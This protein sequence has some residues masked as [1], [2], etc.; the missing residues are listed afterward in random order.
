VSAGGRSDGGGGGRAGTGIAEVAVDVCVVGGGPAG[1]VVAR[2][3]ARL[4]HAVAVVERGGHAG[5]ERGETL[6]PGAWDVLAYLG[7]TDAVL[8]A[9]A[10]PVA[11]SLT[12]WQGAAIVERTGPR[13]SLAVVRPRLDAGLLELARA[14]GATV[15]QP[16]RAIGATRGASGWEIVVETAGGAVRRLGARVVIDASGRAAWRRDG[17]D[18]TRTTPPTFAMRGVWGGGPLPDEARI[19]ALD[20][21][22]IWG[23]P[24]DGGRYAVVAIADAEPA[25]G[26]DRYRA[27]IERSELFRALASGAA[28]AAGFEVCDATAHAAAT[29][30]EDYLIRVGDASYSLDPLSSAGLHVALGSALHAVAA[31][32]TLLEHP[33]RAALVARFYDDARRAEIARHTAWTAA[34]YA[35]CHWRARPFWHQRT[36]STASAV[37]AYAPPA[38]DPA[39]THVAL[40]AGVA[41]E[42]VPCLAGDLVE[43]RLG[44]C[45]PPARPFVWTDGVAVAPLLAPLQTAPLTPRGLLATWRDVPPARHRALLGWLLEAGIVVPVLEQR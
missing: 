28:L 36:P 41:L 10:R 38:F 42:E 24:I 31:T 45:H 7:I 39:C 5:A 27:M 43:S 32:H 13:A 3:L 4:G 17:R 18:R 15:L 21:G 16:A 14:A 19:E 40:A 29:G 20:D 11:R 12:R 8:A 33:D 30:C 25:L 22:W 37:A 2:Q 26:V 1:A 6:H 44:V 34:L 35:D 9:G 23:A